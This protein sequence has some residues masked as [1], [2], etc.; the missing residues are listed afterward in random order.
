MDYRYIF[1]IVASLICN[2]YDTNAQHLAKDQPSNCKVSP[3]QLVITQPD[4]SQLT[5]IGKGN[6]T[7]SWTET[8]DGYSIVRVNGFYEYAQKLNGKLISSGVR[9]HEPAMRSAAEQAFLSSSSRA[10]QPDPD[11]LKSSIL[12]QVNAQLQNK[13]Y[14]T[15]GNVRILAL[16]I[17]YP[18]LNNTYP[19]SNFDSLLYGSNYR[20]GDGSFKTFYETSSNGQ[21]TVTV[22]VFGWFMADSSYIWYGRDSGSSRAA[23]LVREAVDAAELSGVDFSLY[24]NDGD[25]DVDGILAVHA[26]PGAESGSQTQYIWSHR[27]VLNGGTQ[28]AVNYDGVFINDYMINPETRGTLSNPRMV[29]IGVFCHEFG[30]NLGLPDLYDTDN[31]N[32]DSEGIGNWGLMAGAG[33]LGG[34]HRP[35]NFCA[36]SRIEN[37]WDNPTVLPVNSSGQYTLNPSSTTP[38]EIFR[39][40]TQLS[41]EYFLLENRQKIGLD[42]ELPGEGMAIWHINSNKTNSFGNSVNADENLKGVDLEEAD[43]LNDLDNEVN[44]GDNGDLFP[45]TSNNTS[46]TDNT[47]PNA[48]TYTLANT[49]LQIRNISENSNTISFDF[50]AAPGPPCNASTTLT[51]NSGS[52]DDGSGALDYAHNQSCSWLIQPPSGIITLNFTSFDTEAINDFVSVYDGTNPSAPLLG[53]FSGNVLPAAL[54]SSSNSLYV[55]FNSNSTINASGWSANYTTTTGGMPCGTDTLLTSSGTFSDGSGSSNYGNNLNCTWL[56]QPPGASTITFGLTS[57]NTEINVDRIRIYDGPTAASPLLGSYS[58]TNNLNTLTST[59][60]SIFVEF[61]TNSTNTDLGWDA[62]YTSSTSGPGCTGSTTL[63]ATSGSFS[64]GSGPNNYDNNQFCSWLIQPPSGI[65]TLSFSSFSTQANFD[66]VRVYDGIDNTAPQIANLSGNSIPANIV[67]SSN[68]LYLEFI[69]NGSVTDQGWDASYTT[70][71]SGSCSGTTNLTAT[72]GNFNDGSGSSNYNNNLNCSWLIQPTGSPTTISLTMNSMNLANFGD[73]VI[74]YDGTNNTAPIIAAYTGTN[75][76]TVAN[77]YSGSMFVEFTTDASITGAGW[78]ASYTTSSSYCLPSL[79]FTANNGN[80]DDGSPFGANYLNNTDCSWLIQPTASNVIINLSLF[81][82][83]TEALNDTITI[84]DGATTSDPILQTLSGTIPNAVL[85]ST[86]GSMLITFKTNGTITRNGWFASYNTSPIPACSGQTLLTSAS[87]TFDDGSGNGNQYSPNSNCTWLIQPPG[88]LSISLGFNYFNTENNFDFVTVYDGATTGAPVLGTFSGNSIPGTFNSSSGSMLIEFTSDPGI[89]ANGWEVS[90]TSSSVAI[91]NGSPDT[92]YINPGAGSTASF[93]LSS[94]LQWS[95]SDNAPWLVSSPNT[96]SGGSNINLLAIQA[97]IGPERSAEVYINATGRSEKD[98]VIVI[99]RSS[100]KYLTVTPDTLFFAGNPAGSQSS[101]ISTNVNWTASNS[102][103][104]ISL[105]S[106]SGTGNA[107][108]SVS[109]SSNTGSTKRTGFIVFSGSNGVSNDTVFVVQDTIVRIPSLSVDPASLILAQA[110]GSN[111]SFTVN[112]TVVWQTQ[113]GASWLTV[114]NPAITSDTNTVQIVANSMNMGSTNRDS[115]VA[116]QDVSGTL[117]DTVYVSQLG[118]AIVLSASPKNITLSQANGSSDQS[119]LTS[120]LSWTASSGATWLSAT[121]ANGNGN[122]TINIT[123][124]SANTSTQTRSSYI[125]L[126]GGSGTLF[127]TIFVDQQGLNPLL[128]VNPASLSLGQAINSLDTF[129]V[130]ANVDWQLSA[131]AS[132]LTVNAFAGT[133]DTS[134]VEIVANTANTSAGIRST[135]VA[136]QDLNGTLFDTLFVNQFGNTLTLSSSPDTVLIGASSG[137]SGN[138]SITTNTSWTSQSGNSIFSMTPSSANGSTS[139]TISVNAD[140]TSGVRITSFIA[141]EDLAQNLFDTI[142]VIQDTFPLGLQTTPD[143][144]RL[145]AS[146]GSTNSFSVST[147]FPWSASPSATWVKVTP[148]TSTG[149]GT[150]TVTANSANTSPNERIS[151][152]AVVAISGA[153]YEDTVYVIQEGSQN[154]LSV[155]PSA[156][157]LNSTAGSNEVLT[158]NSNTNWTVTNPV[159]W[160]SVSPGSG[161]NNG[162]VSVTANSDNLSGASRSANLAFNAPGVGTEIVSVTQIDGSSPSFDV[163]RDTVFVNNPQGS[164]GSF[165]VLANLV[166]WT[167]SENTPWFT[168]NPGSGNNTQVITILVASKNVDGNPRYG[169]ITASAP[170]YADKTITVVQQASTP[171]IQIAPTLLLIGPD[172]ADFNMLRISSNLIAWTITENISW[173]EVTPMNGAKTMDLTVRATED[174]TS[175]NVRSDVITVSAPPFVPQ[176]IMI[177]QDTVRTIGIRESGINLEKA[178]KIYPNPS[179]GQVVVEIDLSMNAKKLSVELYNQL[180]AKINVSPLS[181]NKH[182]QY[183]N[184]S[185]Y[186]SGVY[187]LKVTV[188]GEAIRRKIVLTD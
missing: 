54:T 175:G 138:V 111:A 41:N 81:N 137:N 185:Q 172:S 76:G 29:G 120:N 87:G 91:L 65:I 60:G 145:G 187:F 148:G 36:W 186:A 20:S 7:T 141:L 100:G 114:N 164:T 58:G 69:T 109:V 117:F 127:D 150:V 160:L 146:S 8:I 85:S 23:D 184:L 50:G 133:T 166:N 103:S 162:S 156:V 168:I 9:A 108:P 82:I 88:A 144:I 51:A 98:T 167:L 182:K 163:S 158:V 42:L 149:S 104:W 68:A 176:S 116:V 123:A 174:N 49:N 4:N 46:F 169:N 39:I 26:G 61:T 135:F 38:N 165:S 126:D 93:T 66:R 52:F 45:G 14:P 90:Y 53:N 13:T 35:G 55:E 33:Y 131:G 19:A 67:S 47:T 72:S 73:M 140:N 59:G 16:L 142:V 181:G 11:P 56:I 110:S 70:S 86:G 75:T 44:R 179:K 94:N 105:G 77:A 3:E 80:F 122:A 147:T 173:A 28:G 124:L 48:Q 10:I 136:V 89:Q 96:G 155:S 21:L 1:L 161:S 112:S 188:N 171:V 18:D 113:A 32:G 24:D 57:L 143:T 125:A 2:S 151:Y 15:I 139:A 101:N 177:T 62:Y 134:R 30:H 92:V 34:E 183:F 17:E 84:Y 128:S 121:P 25:F 152:I 130:N 106:S 159:A 64:D 119:V 5:I 12:N 102:F 178:V 153:L 95:I 107:S 22:D 118:G 132:W 63:T 27:W 71:T 99:Q 79:T 129:T 78:D 157:N 154:S 74:V 37:G 31:S 170:G 43:G 180:G 97:N 6:M 83:R 115:Y 40:N